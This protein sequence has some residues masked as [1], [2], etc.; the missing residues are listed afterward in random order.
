VTHALPTPP[1][2]SRGSRAANQRSLSPSHSRYLGEQKGSS[3]VVAIG[4]D[5]HREGRDNSARWLLAFSRRGVVSEVR[6]GGLL[7]RLI[8]SLLSMVESRVLMVVEV[9]RHDQTLPRKSG[10]RST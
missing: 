8:G 7:R 9:L 4:V 2:P 1:A 5:R 3:P 6:Q 10:S